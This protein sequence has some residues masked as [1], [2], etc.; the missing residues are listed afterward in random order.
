MSTN[1]STRPSAN[2]PYMMAR[3][4]AGL[5]YSC[6]E[7]P[8]AGRK[9]CTA[10]I[11]REAEKRTKR[12]SGGLC[13]CGRM[14][15][16]GSRR[17]P[18][19]LTKQ[20]KAAVT[21]RS[22]QAALGLCHCGAKPQDGFRKCER[23]RKRQQ[24]NQRR[25]IEAGFCRCGR[26]RLEN[27]TH[28]APCIEAKFDLQNRVRVAAFTGYGG[29]CVCCGEADFN[30]LELDH[31]NNDGAEHR[32]AVGGGQMYRWAIE[33]GFPAILQLLCANCHRAKTRTGDCSY[34]ATRKQSD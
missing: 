13:D 17:C 24:A 15:S 22:R 3:R 6:G 1:Q 18:S 26:P 4:A 10:C 9:S 29:A 25:R 33:N 34:R 16:A 2:R 28:C 21:F 19:C 23:C 20:R 7:P 12:R 27:R 8:A 11:N 32:R 5:C 30:V 14:P 31:V